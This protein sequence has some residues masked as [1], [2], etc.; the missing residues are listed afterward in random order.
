[1]L[2]GPLC[3]PFLFTGDETMDERKDM[4]MGPIRVMA[5]MDGLEFQ[6]LAKLLEKG[7][8]I[9]EKFKC[10]KEAST[11]AIHLLYRLA[12]LFTTPTDGIISRAEK[13]KIPTKECPLFEDLEETLDA[14]W[15]YFARFS[16]EGYREFLLVGRQPDLMLVKFEKEIAA[17][18]DELKT[19]FKIKPAFALLL[20][21][22]DTSTDK[23]TGVS[24]PKNTRFLKEFQCD[25]RDTAAKAT[26]TNATMDK[27]LAVKRFTTAREVE[28]F[29]R[30]MKETAEFVNEAMESTTRL[31]SVG[32]FSIIR[33]CAMRNFWQ[34]RL[35]NV[36]SVSLT[37]LSELLKTHLIEIF[38]V[39]AD[40]AQG[41]VASCNKGPFKHLQVDTTEHV[42]IID[43][44]KLF[45]SVS[46]NNSNLKQVLHLL[47]ACDEKL[48]IE[49]QWV[50]KK[51]PATQQD[52]YQ[53]KKTKE[54]KLLWDLPVGSD[55]VC[56]ILPPLRN[57]V[58]VV[59]PPSSS[60]STFPPQKMLPMAPLLPL[61]IPTKVVAA[62]PISPSAIMSAAVTT[63]MFGTISTPS[64]DI[65]S[66]PLHIFWNVSQ[67]KTLTA[68]LAAVGWVLLCGPRMVGKSTR[69]LSI[70]QKESDGEKG[71]ENLSKRDK[72]FIDFWGV[73]S[74]SEALCRIVSQLSMKQIYD[75]ETFFAAL[76]DFFS[77]LRPNAIVVL[78]NFDSLLGL[79]S[80]A[81][82]KN[83]RQSV[84]ISGNG[85]FSSAAGEAAETN[86]SS[87]PPNSKN[88]PKSFAR[89][90]L[91][92]LRPWQATFCVVLIA[93]SEPVNSPPSKS[94]SK[95]ISKMKASSETKAG[96]DVELANGKSGNDAAEELKDLKGHAQFQLPSYVDEI[97]SSLPEARKI[98]IPP[99][100]HKPA[101]A[102]A[103]SLQ[104]IDAEALVLAGR[105]C[106]GEMV[107]LHRFCSLKAIRAI[108]SIRTKDRHGSDSVGGKEKKGAGESGSK[109][110]G[111][112][113]RAN[114]QTNQP[115]FSHS[116][117]PGSS[118]RR[119]WD[120]TT[121][122]LLKD[123][124]SVLSHDELL[125]AFA[126]IPGIPPIGEACGWAL[127]RELFSGDLLR[128]RLAWRGLIRS[129]WLIQV[130]D[131]GFVTL[132]PLGYVVASPR[133]TA[134]T[135]ENHPNFPPVPPTED[136]TSENGN[137]IRE[138]R[139]SLYLHYWAAELTRIDISCSENL[140]NFA[141]F[142]RHYQHFRIMF[143]SLVA[144]TLGADMR[145]GEKLR[146]SQQNGKEE[147][148]ADKDPSRRLLSFGR[149][150]SASYSMEGSLDKRDES[151]LEIP[152]FFTSNISALG[153]RIAGHLSRLLSSRF[154]PSEGTLIARAVL[155]HVVQLSPQKETMEYL[156]AGTDL[157]EQ[158]R[159]S[160]ALLEGCALLR[161]IIKK[162][163]IDIDE[164]ERSVETASSVTAK[165]ELKSLAAR[166]MSSQGS[167]PEQRSAV[168]RALFIYST[169]LHSTSRQAEALVYSRQ[170]IK[171]WEK[172]PPTGEVRQRLLLATSREMLL[173][174]DIQSSAA[175]AN[176]KCR[177]C[178]IL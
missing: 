89:E 110:S 114:S 63:A 164:E 21:D 125:A 4:F 23:K 39:S 177:L 20:E 151:E 130:G 175:V 59:L 48:G 83:R 173:G 41:L 22:R 52:F 116:L 60:A 138:R 147:V 12:L 87:A 88:T 172:C 105:Y 169:L 82:P 29:V 133:T 162:F 57:M 7:Y 150:L 36:C 99:L 143:A 66:L 14:A 168:A 136:I 122:L 27:M 107:L 146:G 65:D 43:I 34:D 6:Y 45:D 112:K 74:E 141:L 97:L 126:V 109:G 127:C 11:L 165:V 148:G 38:A 19:T 128:W 144:S 178:L 16:D 53:N 5:N 159:R 68:A 25:L 101:L 3:G 134:L 62:S 156:T 9:F 67:E 145:S 51:D 50:R 154:P 69:V 72:V 13:K 124:L 18:M 31:V 71:K 170:A 90:L 167:S 35:Q 102:M 149:S 28:H 75:T 49:S 26:A 47:A 121:N 10:E 86:S 106:P 81:S 104:W 123:I 77:S 93:H 56:R 80:A 111:T 76:R 79:S 2:C 155:Q 163:P 171:L 15:K 17:I 153:M 46:R 118:L 161:N 103:K 70:L 37:A 166:N 8:S 142:D 120:A 92:T 55:V 85:M 84:K 131:L 78:D 140:L 58:T 73:S 32:A 108:A 95:T 98:S 115:V 96:S 117:S 91:E 54:V 132:A 158:L 160:G 42:D 129:G 137:I 61:L 40:E 100:S 44:S 113:G 139:S 135:G 30:N 174:Q 94:K 152:L 176:N 33:Q 119:L 157:G 24:K 1:M 64:G